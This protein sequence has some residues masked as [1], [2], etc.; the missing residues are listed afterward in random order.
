MA[1]S[2]CKSAFTLFEALVVTVISIFV[3]VLI[4]PSFAPRTNRAPRIKCVS[5]LKQ[6]ALGA[7]LW[8]NDH[9]ERFPWQVSTSNRGT[10]ELIESAD[11]WP[12]WYAMRVELESPKILTCPS[13]LQR[14]PSIRYFTGVAPKPTSYALNLDSSLDGT[15][16]LLSLDR[17][18]VRAGI[19]LK[20]GRHVITARKPLNWNTDIHR[21][22]GNIAFCDGSVLQ[23]TSAELQNAFRNSDVVTN[24]LL[25]P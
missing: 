4:L 21:S 19:P 12:H 8:A 11:T 13:D 18:V 16:A 20:S 9:G 15:N 22:V 17:N 10:L 2:D 6:V 1:T 24:R 3:L 25:F 23:S 5:N 7:R 14:Q